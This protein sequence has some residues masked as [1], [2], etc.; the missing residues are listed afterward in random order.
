MGK[1]KRTVLSTSEAA[2]PRGRIMR[3]Q[4]RMTVENLVTAGFVAFAVAASLGY[5][6]ARWR[7]GRSHRP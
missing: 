3:L 5:Q 1:M 7:A 4:V 6:L 2:A